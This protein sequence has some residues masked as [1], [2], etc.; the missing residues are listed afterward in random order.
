MFRGLLRFALLMIVLAAAAAFF[1]G[2][3]FGDYGIGRPPE[4]PVATTGAA[5]EV[6][7]A[8]ARATGAKIGEKVAAGANQAERALENGALTAKI[9]AKMA[10]DDSVKALDINVDTANGVVTLT[11]TVHSE[12]ERTR[13]VQLA[14]ETAGV[15]SVTD[16][17]TVR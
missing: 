2:Y 10:L 11:G 5:P 16:R 9:K 7:T 6:D 3:R 4:R 8:R 15:T 12:A 14:R 17:L 13:A 1:M